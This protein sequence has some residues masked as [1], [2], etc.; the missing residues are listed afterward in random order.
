[1]TTQRQ[2][3]TIDFLFTSDRAKL[4]TVP[5]AGTVYRSVMLNAHVSCVKCGGSFEDGHVARWAKWE[6]R[7]GYQHET[8]PAKT[9]AELLATPDPL[10]MLE[11]FEGNETVRRMISALGVICKT[12]HI[13]AYLLKTDPMALDQ[14]ELSIAPAFVAKMD[15]SACNGC[16]SSYCKYGDESCPVYV[17]KM[18][19][20]KQ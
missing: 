9:E 11:R 17:A 15:G 16:G 12:G 4:R 18:K 8:C 5:P 14:V 6:G 19:G 13:R 3:S 20:G 2:Y 7:P 1:M 10:A